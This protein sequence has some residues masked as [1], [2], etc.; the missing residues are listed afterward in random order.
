VIMHRLVQLVLRDRSRDSSCQALLRGAQLLHTPHRPDDEPWARRHLVNEHARQSE[1]LMANL[2]P[3]APREVAET[4]FATRLTK[5]LEVAEIADLTRA[6]LIATEVHD[7]AHARLGE[8]HQLVA[9]ALLIAGMAFPS[10]AVRVR[11]ERDLTRFKKEFGLEH[12]NTHAAAMMLSD[13]YRALD[14]ADEALAVLHEVLEPWRDRPRLAEPA[15]ATAEALTQAYLTAGRAAE[16]ISTLERVVQDK[17]HV[18]GPDTR[19][20]LMTMS[21]LADA[22]EAAERSD[23][24]LKVREHVS[25][26]SQRVLGID[27]PFTLINAAKLGGTLTKRGQSEEARTLLEET[28]A[29]AGRVLSEDHWIAALAREA[30]EAIPQD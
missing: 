14:R 30:L 8:K 16:A 17:I 20:T 22:Y 19:S 11:L 29:L 6:G 9:S 27:H 3:D 4:V 26:A 15:F 21:M 25:D 28:R 1:A 24:A 18:S 7:A 2:S 10:D 23:E 13:H 12:I 5:A